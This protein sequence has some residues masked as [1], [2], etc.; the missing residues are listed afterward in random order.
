MIRRNVSRYIHVKAVTG[1]GTKTKRVLFMFA[2]DL[3][4]S[5]MELIAEG[6]QFPDEIFASGN[7]ELFMYLG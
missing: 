1:K 2:K 6:L 4:E 7:R 5:F 3:S